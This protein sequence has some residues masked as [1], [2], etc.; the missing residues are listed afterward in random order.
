MSFEQNPSPEKMGIK[1]NKKEGVFMESGER[2]RL[3]DERLRYENERQAAIN[4]ENLIRGRY[5]ADVNSED[6]QREI[7]GA[8]REQAAAQRMI[9]DVDER[10]RATKI[11]R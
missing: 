1:Q 6:A 4:K 10:L 8:Q 7:V 11:E 5:G 3:F 9:D 2:Q